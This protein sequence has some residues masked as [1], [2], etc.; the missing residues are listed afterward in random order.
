[1]VDI[2][3]STLTNGLRVA[4]QADPS[5]PLV[6]VSLTYDVGSRVESPATSGFAHLFEHL[7][8][9]GSAHVETGELVR[10]IQ[11]WGGTVNGSTNTERTTYYHSL[12]AHQFELGL[13]LEADRMRSLAITPATLENQRATVLAEYRERVEQS[14]YGRAHGRISEISYSEFAY[15]HPVI[16]SRETLETADITAVERFYKT[17]YRPDNAV[18]SIVGDVDPEAVL[19]T[20]YGFFADISRGGDRPVL[21]FAESQRML[22]V[23][24]RMSDAQAGLPAVFANHPSVPYGDPDFYV[25]EVLETLLF[26]GASSRLQR[27]LVAETRS[28][29]SLKG[30]YE[31]H[32]GPSLFSLFAV[33]PE[34]REPATVVEAYS[35]ELERL[36]QEC[37]SSDELEK[38]HNQ[39]RANRVF[40]RVE[41][42]NRAN[43]LARAVMYHNDAHFEDRYLERVLRVTPEDILRVARRDF[44]P[45]ARVVLEV[46]PR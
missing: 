30:G 44:D 46:M 29:I 22:P 2:Q 33:L 4:I 15:G 11:G 35:A 37:V 19:D 42:I 9:Q 7:M 31:A 39:L 3:Q 14:P 41:I 12:P 43:T 23:C 26:R 21:Q 10:Q 45:N 36:T 32:R 1:M 25:Y 20:V 8:F 40:G 13:W 18:L 28:A 16:G 6:G 5:V 34:G 27:R 24:E 17:W 38:V